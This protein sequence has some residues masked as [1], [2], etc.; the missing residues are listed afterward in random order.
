MTNNHYNNNPKPLYGCF[1]IYT[2][3]LIIV[4]AVILVAG[5]Y[6]RFIDWDEGGMLVVSKE[7]INGR[8]PILD[9]NSH[10]Q[11]LMY[12]FYGMSMKLFGF[13]VIAARSLSAA[14]CSQ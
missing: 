10:N 1:N 8:I 5:V 14:A 2:I 9:I 4:H 6:F 3:P 7:I 13:N 11:P 12:Y